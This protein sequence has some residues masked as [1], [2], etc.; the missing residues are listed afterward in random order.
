MHGEPLSEITVQSKVQAG[1]REAGQNE[2]HG[3]G[4]DT[5]PTATTP[6]EALEKRDQNRVPSI[7]FQGQVS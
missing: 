4:E 7:P 6:E 5:T 2:G 1:V 3:H